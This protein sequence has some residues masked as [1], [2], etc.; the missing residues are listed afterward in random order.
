MAGVCQ[1]GVRALW[2]RM[3]GV[4]QSGVRAL[5]GVRRPQRGRGTPERVVRDPLQPGHPDRR[6][7]QVTG[8][9]RVRRLERVRREPLEHRRE[10]PQLLLLELIVADNLAERKPRLGKLQ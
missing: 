5:C 6:A 1:S 9:Q 10:F 4:C 8:R 7:W 2:I 3:A